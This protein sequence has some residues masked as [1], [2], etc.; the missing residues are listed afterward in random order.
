MMQSLL[1]EV[2]I[3]VLGLLTDKLPPTLT[4]HNL[5]HTLDVVEGAHEICTETGVPAEELETLEIAAWFHDTGYLKKYTGHEEVS[6][7]I[8]KQFLK[9]KDISKRRTEEIIGCINATKYPQKPRNFLEKV[10]CDAD[11][12]HFSLP[13]YLEKSNLLKTEWETYLGRSFTDNSWKRENCSLLT[14]HNYFTAYGQG[15]L[16]KLKNFNLEKLKAF[17]EK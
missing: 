1:S 4:F 7:E 9:T 6:I 8:A 10:I 5:A 12:Y 2:S 13:D 16:Q 17:C 14:K 3:Y 11:L 15:T